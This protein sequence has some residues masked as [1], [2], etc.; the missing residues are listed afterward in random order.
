[1]KFYVKSK[2]MHYFSMHLIFVIFS[3]FVETVL[4]VVNCKAQLLARLYSVPNHARWRMVYEI[5]S[6]PT[7][8]LSVATIILI[9]IVFLRDVRMHVDENSLMRTFTGEGLLNTLY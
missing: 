5:S 8:H 3:R 6:V 9:Q 1:M 4:N 7:S 2:D